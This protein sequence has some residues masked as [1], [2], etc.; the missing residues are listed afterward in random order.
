MLRSELGPYKYHDR[1]TLLHICKLTCNGT[2][3]DRLN[4][5]IILQ[6][7]RLIKSLNGN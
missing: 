6:T 7:E 2:K 4:E 1:H 5:S 3:C